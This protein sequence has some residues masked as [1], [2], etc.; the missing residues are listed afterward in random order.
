MA[1][2]HAAQEEKLKEASKAFDKAIQ[3]RDEAAVEALFATDVMIHKGVRCIAWYRQPV[4]YLHLENSRAPVSSKFVYSQWS[5]YKTPVLT[6][7]TSSQD[8]ALS[9]WRCLTDGLTLYA[10]LHG[11]NAAV[12]WVTAY[13]QLCELYSS[14]IRACQTLA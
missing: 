9:R 11:K 3:E 14:G 10:D 7:V 8:Q 6:A 12:D 4:S 13:W 2:Q 5:T 1:S